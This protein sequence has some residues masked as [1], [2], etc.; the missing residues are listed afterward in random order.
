MRA[1]WVLPLLVLVTLASI[2]VLYVRGD[3]NPILCDGPC[4]PQFVTPPEGLAE[5]SPGPDP[6]TAVGT[7]PVDGDQLAAA[8]AKPFA[9]AALGDRA[10][11]VAL[12][13]RDGTVLVED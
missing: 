8:V 12:D 6:V 3:L 7:A 2:A 9:S 1:A 10:S 4:A 11:V 5:P 13:A